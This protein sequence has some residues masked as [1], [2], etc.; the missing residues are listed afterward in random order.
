MFP[1]SYFTLVGEEHIHLSGGQKQLLALARAL[2]HKPH[3][4]LLDEATSAMDSKMEN[5]VLELFTKLKAEM[6]ILMITHKRQIL[7]GLD[8]VVY[9]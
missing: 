1:Q 4:L 3:L 8:K 5:F 7:E 2:Y 6:M 9:V